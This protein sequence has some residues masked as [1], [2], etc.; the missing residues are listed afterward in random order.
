MPALLKI[1][2]SVGVNPTYLVSFAGVPTGGTFTL[3]LT[4]GINGP[5]PNQQ[6]A[7]ITYTT[8]LTPAAVQTAIQALTGMSTV[9]VTGTN[10]GPFTITIPNALGLGSVVMS[11][12]AVTGG[13]SP[14]AFVTPTGLS[15]TVLTVG[16]GASTIIKSAAITNGSTGSATIS[17]SLIP[18]GG[19]LDGT[20]RVLSSY[21]LLPNDTITAS[22]VLSGLNGVMLE[23]GAAVSVNAT[24]PVTVTLTGAVIS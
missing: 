23:T 3:T 12:S 20:H 13:T 17:V 19:S 22:D 1:L 11:T 21:A 24:Q 16:A 15:T 14:T 10:G 6:A 8:T 18:A 5:T 4:T 7:T 2:S 9:T